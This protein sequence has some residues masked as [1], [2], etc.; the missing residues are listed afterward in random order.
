MGEY[1]GGETASQWEYKR[2]VVDLIVV[3]SVYVVPVG[4]G[5]AA[6]QSGKRWL[7]Q[8]GWYC[9]KILHSIEIRHY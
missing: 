1:I 8:I 5:T 9:K 7:N 2:P 6:V 3:A 4:Q